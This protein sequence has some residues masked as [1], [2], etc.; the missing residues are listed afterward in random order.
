MA[1]RTSTLVHRS[2][3][4]YLSDTCEQKVILDDLN[5]GCNPSVR[6]RCY[7]STRSL[8]TPST[9]TPFE[10]RLSHFAESKSPV[11]QWRQFSTGKVQRGDELTHRENA[12]T[13]VLFEQPEAREFSRAYSSISRAART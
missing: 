10:A 11:T 1:Y 12:R 6:T 4:Q 2:S 3:A 5:G 7:L 9:H 13:P 8:S